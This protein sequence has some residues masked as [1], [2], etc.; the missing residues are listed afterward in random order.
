MEAQAVAATSPPEQEVASNDGLVIVFAVALL[1]LV[2]VIGGAMLK[3]HFSGIDKGTG[4][5][6]E[7]PTTPTSEDSGVVTEE[8]VD[9]QSPQSSLEHMEKDL[10]TVEII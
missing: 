9:M 1:S 10:Q 5:V 7:D 6:K 2:A 4:T 3:R 8:T